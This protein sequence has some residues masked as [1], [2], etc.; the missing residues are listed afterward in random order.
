MCMYFHTWVA[1]A[2]Y[3][4]KHARTR[5]NEE[6]EPKRREISPAVLSVRTPAHLRDGHNESRARRP[7]AE[8]GM[9]TAA[10]VK[11]NQHKQRD[12]T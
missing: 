1:V 8:G 9:A 12:D 10:R 2:T 3:K 11:T 5:V 6:R 7:R 4:R